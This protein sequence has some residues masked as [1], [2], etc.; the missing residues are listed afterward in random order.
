MPSYIDKLSGGRERVTLIGLDKDKNRFELELDLVET[1]ETT[2]NN[3]ITSHAIEKDPSLPVYKITDHVIPENPSIVCNCILSDNLNLLSL[4]P[5]TISAKDKL[6]MLTYWQRSGAI[7]TLEGYTVG[8]GLFGKILNFFKRGIG[9]FNSELEEPYYVGT[10]TE[11]IENLCLGTITSRNKVE[12]GN[13][14]EVT[15]NLTRIHIAEARTVNRMSSSKTSIPNK[16]NTPTQ[17]VKPKKE[18]IKSTVKKGVL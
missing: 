10:V 15:L 9:N 16:G 14:I 11:R 2:Y 1:F 4:K 7:L 13:D 12:L 18:V 17:T 8:S 6:Q 3:Q 5:K